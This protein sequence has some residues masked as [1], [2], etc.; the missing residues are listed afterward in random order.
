M[1]RNL[2][3]IRYRQVL[4]GVVSLVSPGA[5]ST[6]TGGTDSARYCYSVWLRHVVRLGQAGLWN[7]P[8]RV[9][10]LGPGDSIGTGLA[11]L[12]TGAS[13]YTGLDVV[14]YTDMKRSLPILDELAELVG[15]QEPIPDDSEF[16]EVWPKLDSYAFPHTLLNT[17]ATDVKQSHQMISKDIQQDDASGSVRYHAPLHL[18]ESDLQNQIELLWS[19]AVME[20][21]DDLERTYRAMSQWLTPGGIGSHVIDFRAHALSTQWDGHHMY[22]D[23]LLRVARGSRAYLLNRE[24]LTRHI[25]ELQANGFR[26]EVL[27]RGENESTGEEH[28]YTPRYSIMSPTDRT[29]ALAY[30]IASRS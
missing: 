14:P 22:P 1:P 30:L 13:V 17:R 12:L 8:E 25:E 18:R 28:E 5:A 11:A 27:E 23:W 19:Q 21:V 6:G 4:L 7:R 24:P 26:I 3:A 9:A 10:E 20:H 15:K 16:P 29:T 2:R